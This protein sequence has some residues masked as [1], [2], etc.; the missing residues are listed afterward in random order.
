MSCKNV[1]QSIFFFFK[2]FY[3]FVVRE[4]AACNS[5]GYTI[6]L[7]CHIKMLSHFIIL[8]QI[9][10]PIK[11][12]CYFPLL[13]TPHNCTKMSTTYKPFLVFLLVAVALNLTTPSLARTFLA[14][15]MR[16]EYRRKLKLIQAS[17]RGENK[18]ALVCTRLTCPA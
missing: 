15:I 6:T 11:H 10:S 4:L 3:L 16:T 9:F 13:R 8:L 17:R 14:S 18:P 7:Q 1:V 2:L 5:C 12:P